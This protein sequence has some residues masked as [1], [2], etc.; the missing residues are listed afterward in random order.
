M[1][2][3]HWMILVFP[4]INIIHSLVDDRISTE[5][6]SQILVSAALIAALLFWGQQ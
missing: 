1:S 6:R 2:W 4:A 3:Q 5:R